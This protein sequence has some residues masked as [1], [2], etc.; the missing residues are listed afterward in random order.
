M[1]TDSL[2]KTVAEQIYKEQKEK[3]DA[4]RDWMAGYCERVI[5]NLEEQLKRC[6]S[7]SK[8]TKILGRLEKWK[9][10]QKSILEIPSTA[11]SK[12]E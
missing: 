6:K 1:D 5:P 11:H 2:A 10:I 3:A 12:T 9:S 8:K 7:N 4:Y